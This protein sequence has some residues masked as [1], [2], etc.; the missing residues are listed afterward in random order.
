MKASN[1]SNAFK[2]ST[3]KVGNN[4][5]NNQLANQP[6]KVPECLTGK[7]Y[8]ITG[9]LR[10]RSVQPQTREIKQFDNIKRKPFPN[11]KRVLVPNG[12]PPENN[13][14]LRKKQFS[15]F[16]RNSQDFD[17]ISKVDYKVRRRPPSCSVKETFDFKSYN[18]NQGYN[19][20][21]PKRQNRNTPFTNYSY[22]SQIYMLPGCVKRQEKEI[23]D[24]AK[25]I[26]SYE[27][28]VKNRVCYQA[29]LNNDYYTNIACLPGPPLNNDQRELKRCSS[30]YYAN[31]NI[32]RMNESDIF[33]LRGKPLMKEQGHLQIS[34]KR[35]FPE[36]NN[37]TSSQSS[38]A[39]FRK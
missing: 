31:R 39:R 32:S 1:S 35:I 33:N 10:K 7:I 38:F 2:I 27:N 14:N 18:S 26:K 5:T 37:I 13:K 30:S 28:K 29:K 15:H 8:E 20:K 25:E 21:L 24:D 34:K 19:P 6:N 23:Y 16:N 36:K 11:S 3:N 12:Y 9:H 22:T 17:Y 4:Q